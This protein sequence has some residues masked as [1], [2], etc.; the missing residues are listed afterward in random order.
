VNAQF[1]AATA[2]PGCQAALTFGGLP[3]EEARASFDLFA[4]EVLPDR[5]HPVAKSRAR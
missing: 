5:D 4:A 3:R 1:D 2:C